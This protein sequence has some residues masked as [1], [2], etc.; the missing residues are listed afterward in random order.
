MV[1]PALIATA[2]AEHFGMTGEEIASGILRFAPT[3]MRMN[4]MNRA[5]NITILNDTYNANP[6]SMRAAVEVLASAKGTIKIA[7]LGDMLELGPLAPALHEGVGEYLGKAG[8][9]CLVAVG[10]LARH[11]YDAAFKALV[12]TV[13]YCKT[14]EEALPILAELVKPGATVLVKASRAMHFESF[15][16]YLKTVTKEP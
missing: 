11:I 4:V 12:P 3:K 2:V 15:V 14:K 7:V 1:Y 5:E 8:I 10:D 6:Q 9:D 16:D 13:Y